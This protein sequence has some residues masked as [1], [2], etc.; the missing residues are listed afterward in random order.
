[1]EAA[2]TSHQAGLVLMPETIRDYSLVEIIDPFPA[3]RTLAE[4]PIAPPCV[5]YWTRLQDACVLPLREA[6]LFYRRELLP[7]LDQG[8]LAVH[9]AIQ[10]ASRRVR[11]K[12][13][14]HLSDL[15]FGTREA[16]KR[17]SWLKEQLARELPSIDRVVV[18]GD[19]FDDPDEPLRESFDEFRLDI[20]NMTHKDLLVIPGNHDV[21]RK[22]NALA[23]FGRNPEYITD[24]RWSPV[25]ADDELQ[26]IFFSFNSSETGNLA[27]GAVGERQRLDRSVLVDREIRRDPRLSEFLKVA[28][29]HHH[30]IAYQSVPTSAYERLMA[31]LGGEE[32]FIAFNNADEFLE[33]CAARGVSLVLHGHKHIPH[34]ATREIHSQNDYKRVTI[35]GCGSTT[36]VEGKPM[37]YDIVTLDPETKRWNVLFYHDEKGDGSGFGIQ[38]VALNFLH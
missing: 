10:I 23:M 18:T 3:I 37:C 21:R 15:H 26:T 9:E 2:I 5:V 6:Q 13:I 28:L 8:L 12:R 22:G 25:V 16:A 38:N 20:E 32:R 27:T 36:G 31:K 24:L 7:A 34:W 11:T 33:W 17:R 4:H 14:L 30:P 1:M 35:V 19:L 29:V